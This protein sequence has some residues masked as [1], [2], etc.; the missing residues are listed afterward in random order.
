MFAL[1]L[2]KDDRN[3]AKVESN[4]LQVESNI[5]RLNKENEWCLAKK[6]FWN[7]RQTHGKTSFVESFFQVVGLQLK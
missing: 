3:I 5:L 6:E 4:I 1:E 2:F 7:I